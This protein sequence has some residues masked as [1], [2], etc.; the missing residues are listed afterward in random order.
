MEVGFTHNEPLAKKPIVF[1]RILGE[2]PG[3]GIVANPA[4]DLPEGIAIGPDNEGVNKPVKCYV[5]EEDALFSAT[6]I[7]IEKGSGVAIGDFIG[8]GK[9]SAVVTDLDDSDPD[10]DEVTVSLGVALAK[11]DK[12]YQAKA[13]S[14]AAVE[15]IAAGYYDATSEDVGAL[16]IVAT[17]A[18]EGEIDLANVNPYRGNR[19]LAA[20]MYVVLVSTPV[21][22]VTGVDA[23]P[24]Y[25]P[26]YLLGQEIPAGQG[27]KLVKLVNIAVVRKE[28][29]PVADE[30][31]ALMSGI[32]KV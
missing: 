15:G 24:L 5:V 13:A 14:V 31:L 28:T 26:D 16:K 12:L 22:E 8:K 4:F 3:G 17:G 25:T 23:E 32:K 2:K 30:V 29:V 1:E 18:G 6:K 10:F 9:V 19:I 27:D 11:G 7:N 20:D 21:A